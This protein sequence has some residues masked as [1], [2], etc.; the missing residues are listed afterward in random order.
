MT[1]DLHVVAVKDAFPIRPGLIGSEHPPGLVILFDGRQCGFDL[2]T[3]GEAVEFVRPDGVSGAAV[4][5]EM[6]EHGD[7]RSM[8]FRDLD[9]DDIPI[10]SVVYWPAR[11][12]EPAEQVASPRTAT[13][14]LS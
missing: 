5:A 2:P 9:K 12:G 14:R 11:E 1:R 10:G 13:A 3:V 7:G 4:V 6:K 8:F